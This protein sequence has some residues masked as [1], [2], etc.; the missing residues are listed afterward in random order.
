MN[1]KVI[2]GTMKIL[3]NFYIEEDDKQKANEKLNRLCG[4]QT[5]GQ[6]ASLLRVMIKTFNNIPDA[7]IKPAFLDAIKAEYVYS[8]SLNKRSKM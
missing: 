7:E 5:K 3:T 2:G 1:V 4:N 6:F 8:Q